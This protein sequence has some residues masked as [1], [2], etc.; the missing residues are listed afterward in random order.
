M[1]NSSPPK[2]KVLDCWRHWSEIEERIKKES[3]WLRSSI[4]VFP[5]E[6]PTPLGCGE[7]FLRRIAIMIISGGVQAT[8]ITKGPSLKGFWDGKIVHNKKLGRYRGG[9]WHRETIAIIENHFLRRGY[10]IVLEPDLQQGRADLLA[11]KKNEPD[12]YIEVG[13][14]TSFFKLWMNLKRMKKRIYL[15]A[16]NDDK[17]IEFIC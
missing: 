8:E 10:K 17:L 11:S 6:K 3:D 7:C 15:I 9:D 1:P 13:T 4:A 5:S 2:L 16:P 12:L 14:I